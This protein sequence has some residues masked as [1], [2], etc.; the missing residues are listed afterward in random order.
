MKDSKSLQ[1]AWVFPPFF[2][3]NEDS[4]SWVAIESEEQG[5]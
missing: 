1:P 2:V 4:G 3:L 5:A